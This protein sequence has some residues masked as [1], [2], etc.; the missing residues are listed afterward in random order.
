[1][2]RYLNSKDF[3]GRPVSKFDAINVSMSWGL[4][5][6][7][8]LLSRRRIFLTKWM[9]SCKRHFS[10]S[11]LFASRRFIQH[12]KFHEFSALSMSR[13]IFLLW[14]SFCHPKSNIATQAYH[15]EL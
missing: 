4:R 5:F 8:A 2:K 9:A 1:M 14:N 12:S 6:V 15:L 13:L 11:L 10:T 3:G 7:N